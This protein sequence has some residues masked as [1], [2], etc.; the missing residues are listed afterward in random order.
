MLRKTMIVL[1]TTAAFTGGLTADALARGGGG[2]G[3][4][5]GFGG[6]G[7]MGGGFGGARIGGAFGAGHI[8]GG[9]LGSGHLG[10]AGAAFA[11]G[12]V[13][14]HFAHREHFRHR[15]VYGNGLYDWCRY[16]YYT[17]QCA[18]LPD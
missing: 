1:I 6:G 12:S 7:H 3:H 17:D 18:Y 13:G 16:P 5:A 15:R 9:H 8:G 4:G 11:R 2:G 10:G 14:S